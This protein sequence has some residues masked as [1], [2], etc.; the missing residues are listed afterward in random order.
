MN[1]E[2]SER[3]SEDRSKA[4][5]VNGALH[6]AAPTVRTPSQ[7]V[8]PVAGE[9]AF[10]YQPI[11][12]ASG[13]AVVHEALVRWHRPGGGVQAPVDFLPSLLEPERISGFT[14]FTIACAVS[15]L[16]QNPRLD[17][18]SI[19]LSPDQLCMD[20]TRD[21]FDRLSHESR[22]RLMIE[23]TEDPIPDLES[24]HLSIGEIANLG[25]N[26]VL[27]DVVPEDI[28]QRLL[29]GLA[30]SGVKFDRSVLP[31]LIGPRAEPAAASVLKALRQLKLH[32]TIEG[33]DD[34]AALPH[35][36][37]LGATRFQGFGLAM[38]GPYLNA[39]QQVGR[40]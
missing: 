31:R 3:S 19:N 11:F 29:N 12:D 10:H 22:E 33:I 28:E 38:P 14:A 25:V 30:V 37:S 4:L 16:E 26:I 21:R 39:D 36:A 40:H 1:A 9:L 32:V 18:I 34:I 27:D 2:T 7:R 35:L 15:T 6:G 17:C 8:L 20:S 5:L 13:R 23:V 24:Y